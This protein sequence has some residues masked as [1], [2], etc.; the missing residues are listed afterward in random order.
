MGL[1]EWERGFEQTKECYLTEVIPFFK[2]L[3]EHFK[4]IQKA[5]TKEIKEMKEILE[6][7]EAEVDQNVVNKKHD[8]IEQKNLLIANDNLISDCLSKDVFY[9]ATNSELTVSRFTEMHATHTVVQ[10]CCLELEA[11][12]SKLLDKVTDIAQ[13]EKTKQN[14][15]NRAREWK[16]YENTEAEGLPIFYGPTRAHLMGRDNEQS[17]CFS[18]TRLSIFLEVLPDTFDILLVHAGNPT[19]F[20]WMMGRVH[21][22][23]AQRLK[24]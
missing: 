3:K 24:F 2:T 5:L 23:M 19:S 14:R 7:L 12:L 4:G 15:Q 9:I 11:E 20:D 16:E 1:T 13:K 8:E 17:K 10:A 21:N 22:P 6:E 18:S